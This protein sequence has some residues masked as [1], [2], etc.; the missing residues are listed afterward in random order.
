MYIVNIR[1]FTRVKVRGEYGY[2]SKT[3]YIHTSKK[4]NFKKY[5]TLYNPGYCVRNFYYDFY[6]IICLF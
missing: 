1:S 4:R 6:C 5:I 2:N 3:F